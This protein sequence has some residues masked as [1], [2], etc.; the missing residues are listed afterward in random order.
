MDA[1][2]NLHVCV[3]TYDLIN[4]VLSMYLDV[5]KEEF[6]RLIAKVAWTKTNA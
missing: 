6:H 4:L 2:F 5:G 1:I 3:H